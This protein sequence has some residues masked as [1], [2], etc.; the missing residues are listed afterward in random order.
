MRR[1][2]ELGLAVGTARRARLADLHSK[3]AV[4]GELQDHIVVLLAIPSHPHI[5]GVVD[6]D[7]V[8]ALRLNRSPRRGRS[9]SAAGGVEIQHRR[10]RALLV[11][12]QRGGPMHD[13]DVVLTVH[14]D[15]R[16][17]AEDPV[18]G[19]RLGPERL[20]LEL[21]H[22]LRQGRGGEQHGRSDG[23]CKLDGVLPDPA[24]TACCSRTR[25]A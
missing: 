2:A 1:A 21:R 5:A 12:E 25:V 11:V 24:A 3:L 13:P 8:L 4:G 7:A 23:G 17:L 18:L 20:G 6:E 22:V 14:R 19:K 15:A 9:S 16:H 10:R